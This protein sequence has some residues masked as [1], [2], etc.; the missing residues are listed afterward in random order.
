MRKKVIVGLMA[1]CCVP[2][3]AEARSEQKP[4]IVFLFCDDLGFGS[5]GIN[6]AQHTSTPNIDQLAARGVNCTQLFSGSATCSPSRA[7]VIT[8]RFPLR[9]DI[10]FAILKKDGRY[11]PAR[12]DYLPAVLHDNGYH[13]A[14]IGKWHLGGINK[15]EEFDARKAGKK[16]TDGP[17][18]HGFDTSVVMM[19]DQSFRMLSTQDGGGIYVN[20]TRYLYR[21]N[22]RIPPYDGHW[23]TAKGDYSCEYIRSRQGSEQPFFLNVW[24][25]VPHSPIELPPPHIMKD[26]ENRKYVGDPEENKNLQQYCAMITHMDEQ[27]GKIVAALKEAGVY[28]NT[29]IAFTSDNGGH[30]KIANLPEIN[31]PFREGKMSLMNGGICMPSLFVWEGRIPAGEERSQVMHQVDLLPT[32]CDAAGIPLPKVTD[33]LSYNGISVLDALRSNTPLPH[34]DL[35]F[36]SNIRKNAMIRNGRW[37]LIRGASRKNPEPTFQLYDLQSD[38]VEANNLIGTMVE[39]EQSMKRAMEAYLNE[40]KT[41]PVKLITPTYSDPAWTSA[42]DWKEAANRQS[43]K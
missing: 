35:F 1:L 42:K 41:S 43:I 14:H 18:E 2:A 30:L 37:K 21:D 38:R 16:I 10:P 40:A 8:G 15:P 25:D 13:C 5:V 31:A 32:F 27:V 23:T 24:F 39:L 22:D 26:Y 20:C 9:V 19:E 7:A 4:N 29:L 11:L 34:R 28:E 36:T 3:F 6:G 12:R 33:S 17:L